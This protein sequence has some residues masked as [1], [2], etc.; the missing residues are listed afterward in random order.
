M[1]V[2]LWNLMSGELAAT[3]PLHHRLAYT[4]LTDA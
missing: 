4:V 2:M 3:L 1:S